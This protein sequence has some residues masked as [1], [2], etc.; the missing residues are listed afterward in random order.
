[1]RPPSSSEA[2]L[3]PTLLFMLRRLLLLGAGFMALDG[4][5]KPGDPGGDVAITA[6]LRTGL[7]NT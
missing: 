1:M 5:G 3:P 7:V 2:L 6:Q 4:R